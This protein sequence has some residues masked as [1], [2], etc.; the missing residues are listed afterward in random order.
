M[1]IYIARRRQTNASNALDVLSIDVKVRLQCAPKVVNM[2][3]R[4]RFTQI[5][6]EHTCMNT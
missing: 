4:A 5:V 2:H 1:S 6:T 3:V